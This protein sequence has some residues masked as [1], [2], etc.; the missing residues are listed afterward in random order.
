MRKISLFIAMS[1]DGYIADSKG[2]VN[3]LKGQ[4]ENDNTNN[5]YS[6]FIEKI[7]TIIMGWNTYHQIVRELSPD[8]WPYENQITYVMKHREEVSSDKIRFINEDLNEFV[9]Q[10]KKEKGKNIWICGEANI[11][12]QLMVQDLI[13]VYNVTIIPTI[14]G[15]GVRLFKKGKNEIKLSLV[16]A[17][18]YNGMIDAVYTRR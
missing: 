1:L 3:W 11:V 17:Q 12:Q 16:K 7:D 4:G 10:L 15:S 9:T 18:T 8:F 13:D 5:S 2:G 14:L 6:E